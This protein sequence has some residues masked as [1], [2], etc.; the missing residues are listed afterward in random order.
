MLAEWERKHPGRAETMFRAIS[1]V[2]PS[3]LADT[4]LFDFAALDA[5]ADSPQSDA[6]AWLA[7]SEPESG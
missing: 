6:H 3:Q 5:V 4:K 2:M 7:D 1:N